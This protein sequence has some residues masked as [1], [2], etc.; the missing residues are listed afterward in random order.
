[1]ERLFADHTDEALLEILDQYG[2]LHDF[3]ALCGDHFEN[4]EQSLNI[5]ENGLR[6]DPKL[7]RVAEDYLAKLPGINA[8]EI[9]CDLLFNA[10]ISPLFCIAL[11]HALGPY[12]QSAHDQDSQNFRGYLEMEYFICGDEFFVHT[13]LHEQ[14]GIWHFQLT[15]DLNSALRWHS[16]AW[17]SDNGKTAEIQVFQE[18]IP[19]AQML[20][21][22]GKPL[23][24]LTDHAISEIPDLKFVSLKTEESSPVLE[25]EGD[26]RVL[27]LGDISKDTA[28]HFQI[29]NCKAA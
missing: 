19:H 3:L 4:T 29:E 1:M 14:N 20:A 12:N 22:I 17:S 26:F 7:H 13:S 9:D 15:I 18:G 5:L 25:V 23:G 28:S 16:K 24:T 27:R 6:G 2:E 10:N 21:L 11:L 8:F